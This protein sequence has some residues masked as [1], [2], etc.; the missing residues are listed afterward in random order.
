MMFY[1]RDD[2]STITEPGLVEHLIN[3]I[4]EKGFTNIALVES[5]NV[6]YMATGL[7]I[8]KLKT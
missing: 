5:Q 8:G 3:K 1:S 7:R 6:Y 2:K 4:S